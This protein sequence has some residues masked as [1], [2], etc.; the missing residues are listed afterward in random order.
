VPEGLGQRRELFIRG[1]ALDR[2]QVGLIIGRGAAG[3]ARLF[4]RSSAIYAK[5]HRAA[6]AELAVGIA[7]SQPLAKIVA[8][9]TMLRYRFHAPVIESFLSTP[10]F[11]SS[12]V[13]GKREVHDGRA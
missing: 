6:S 9:A 2:A 13:H 7:R 1:V 11:P 12:R 4:H 5:I 8:T 3:G 10:G